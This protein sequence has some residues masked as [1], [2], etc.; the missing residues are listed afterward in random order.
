M[1]SSDTTKVV[2]I[3]HDNLHQEFWAKAT[4]SN[5]QSLSQTLEYVCIVEKLS[6]RDA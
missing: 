6:G 4:A 2:I 3:H 5:R 1:P